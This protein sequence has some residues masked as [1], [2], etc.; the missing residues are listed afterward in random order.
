MGMNMMRH[1]R[2]ALRPQSIREVDQLQAILAEAKA[3]AAKESHV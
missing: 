2:L 3:L 1:N